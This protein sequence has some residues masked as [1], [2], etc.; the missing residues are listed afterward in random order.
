MVAALIDK[1]ESYL[2][3][4]CTNKNRSVATEGS[5]RSALLKLKK[6]LETV[7]VDFRV[8]DLLTLEAF[9]GPT[10][11]KNGMGV[12]SRSQAISAVRGFYTYLQRVGEVVNNPAQN[13]EHPRALS[14]LAAMLSLGQMEKLIMSPDLKTF[15][16][17]RDAAIMA[18]LF[19]TG[20]R[21]SGLVNLTESDLVYG[22]DE[23]PP[24]L[25]VLLTE[26]GKKQRKLPLNRTAEVILQ[27]YLQH[28]ELKRIDRETPA[29][30]IVFIS[31]RN[32][33]VDGCD[34]RGEHRRLSRKSITV[35][36][37]DYGT[38]AGI[39]VGQLHPHAARHAV[40]TL[41]YDH[42]MN[43]EDRQAFLG[44]AR[45]DTLQIYTR[46]SEKR[47][48][49]GADAANALTRMST[50][51]EVLVKAFFPDSVRLHKSHSGN[52]SWG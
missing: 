28:E 29:G 47:L 7:G 34:F 51:V 10:L 46:L 13:L 3:W 2:E 27:M 45:A 38:A 33:R 31:L 15:K 6:Y 35:M 18:F 52:K 23:Q 11:H 24:R 41:L 5:Y 20:C 50:P 30:K 16:G 22:G 49:P 43:A 39:P 44:H 32:S 21:V 17:L 25:Y 1:I 36:L 9:T 37:K 42:G 48:L 12:S 40:G 26:K 14:P 8:V 4:L 19:A